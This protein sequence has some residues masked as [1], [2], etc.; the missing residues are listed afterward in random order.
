MCSDFLSAMAAPSAVLH[1]DSQQICDYVLLRHANVV[2]DAENEKTYKVQSVLCC[3]LRLFFTSCVRILSSK[4]A[5]DVC[6][7]RNS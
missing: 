7:F 1:Y 5:S 6:G 4:N 2:K 3:V